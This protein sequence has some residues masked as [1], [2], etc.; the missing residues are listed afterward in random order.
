MSLSK[1]WELVMDREVW[2][3]AIHGVAKSQ[4]WLSNWT[5][6]NWCMYLYTFMFIINFANT[7]HTI[8]TWYTIFFTVIRNT[9]RQLFLIKCFHWYLS[10]VDVLAWKLVHS[11]FCINKTKVKQWIYMLNLL[12]LS[13]NGSNFFTKLDNSLCIWRTILRPFPQFSV[14]HSQCNC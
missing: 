5:E 4:T 1:L 12:L 13:Q 6:V 3:A 10:N 2:R 7:R 11:F 9:Y 8:Y 14:C